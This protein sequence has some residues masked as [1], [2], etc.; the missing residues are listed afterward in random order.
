MQNGYIEK[1]VRKCSWKLITWGIIGI[2]LITSIGLIS[3]SYFIEFFRGPVKLSSIDL[4][5][6][7]RDEYFENTYVFVDPSKLVDTGVF[8][9]YMDD[10]GN[11]VIETRYYF[12]SIDD[13]LIVVGADPEDIEGDIFGELFWMNSYAQSEF[14]EIFE[15]K[16]TGS[17]KRFLPIIFMQNDFRLRGYTGLIIL[18]L[19]SFLSIMLIVKGAKPLRR[20]EN[21][22]SMKDLTRFGS[23]EFTGSRINSEMA[24]PHEKIGHTHFLGSMLLEETRYGFTVMRYEDIVWAFK[25]KFMGKNLGIFQFS[26]HSLMVHDRF[27]KTLCLV[28]KQAQVDRMMTLLLPHMP[29][30][31]KGYTD[32]LHHLWETNPRVILQGV[33]DRKVAVNE[34]LE[35]RPLPTDQEQS[36]G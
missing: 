26:T 7:I 23:L 18:G 21:H 11:E 28:K 2:L 31:Y 30:A 15:T 22:P 8:D 35:I 9:S 24:I 5:K 6:S 10:D 12:A 16:L 13:Y 36:Q 19:V 33:Q 25:Q 1:R 29:Y 17:S 3:S 27:Q 14:G 34:P 32:E 20:M 4:E